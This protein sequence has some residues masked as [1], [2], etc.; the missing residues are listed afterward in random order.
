[1]YMCVAWIAGNSADDFLEHALP[2]RVALRHGVA[3]VRH[4]HRRAARWPPRCSNARA[5]DA[6]DALVGVDL[7]LDRDFVRR[8]GLEPAADAHVDA[9]GVL[10]EHDEVDVLRAAVLQRAE[11]IGEQLD[12]PVVDV[13]VELEPG[14]EQDV[15]RMPH[16][17]ERADRPARR[18][19]IASNSSRSIA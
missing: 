4:A 11:A 8:P 9:L 6:V 17:P 1:M 13:E 2:E 7:F 16:C 18:R 19:R 15:A 5:D 14:A 10:A 12:R 3:L